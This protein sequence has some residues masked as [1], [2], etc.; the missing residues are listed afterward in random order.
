MQDATPENWGRAV[1]CLTF[2]NEAC[3]CSWFVELSTKLSADPTTWRDS[4][5]ATDYIPTPGL[6]AEGATPELLRLNVIVSGPDIFIL[7]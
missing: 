7:L 4:H 6:D 2:E 1:P 5:S 3:N